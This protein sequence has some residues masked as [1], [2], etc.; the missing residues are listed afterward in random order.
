MV[1]RKK[2]P[3]TIYVSGLGI[4]VSVR[5]DRKPSATVLNYKWVGVV[6]ANCTVVLPSLDI[7][8][9]VLSAVVQH[10]V[11]EYERGRKEGHNEGVRSVRDKVLSGLG[12]GELQG[13]VARLTSQVE[14]IKGQADRT[15]RTVSELGSP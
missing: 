5:E 10:M 15:E 13:E 11:R 3:R 7:P 9:E 12:L 2:Q 4:C 6:E 8:D 1:A 14:E